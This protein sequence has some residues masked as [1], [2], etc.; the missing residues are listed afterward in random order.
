MRLKASS[1]CW[2]RFP[3][4]PSVGRMVRTMAAARSPPGCA[5]QRFAYV[6]CLP[7]S[8]SD[9]VRFLCKGAALIL[10]VAPCRKK[11]S[12]E[13]IMFGKSA[14]FAVAVAILAAS[15]C[16]SLPSRDPA[17]DDARLSLDAARR[18]PQVA[19]YA[20][21]EFSQAAATLRQA[22]D[23]AANG[24]RY[25]DVHQLAVLA[26]QRAAAAQDVARSAAGRGSTA[27]GGG[28]AAPSQ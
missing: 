2:K 26:N 22:D 8:E 13:A 12:L 15:G 28:S 16:A 19:M 23:L 9:G 10:C 14:T 4:I 5:T 17:L 7:T 11:R 3:W 24:G 27:T 25:D 21:P 6:G 20:S 18:N 1:P